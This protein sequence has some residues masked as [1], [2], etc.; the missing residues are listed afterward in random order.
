[1]EPIAILFEILYQMAQDATKSL[2]DDEIEELMEKF[3]KEEELKAKKK[4]P[5]KKPKK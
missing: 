2:N 4:P 5:S 1:M 3:K